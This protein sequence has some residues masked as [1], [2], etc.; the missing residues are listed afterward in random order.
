MLGRR[1]V[2]GALALAVWSA[3]ACAPRPN[4]SVGPTNESRVRTVDV[5]IDA[6]HGGR[7]PGN[8]GADRATERQEKHLVLAVARELADELRRR[9][10]TAELVR[11]DDRFLTLGQRSRIAN[12]EIPA[13]DGTQARG[14]LFVSLH[15]NGSIPEV[16]GT[17]SYWSRSKVRAA[18]PGAWRADSAAATAVHAGLAMALGEIF[19]GCSTDRSVREGG[20]SVLRRTE[21]PAVLVEMGFVSNRCQQAAVSDPARRTRLARALADGVRY[22]LAPEREGAQ[23]L[24]EL[25]ELPARPPQE[26]GS[27]PAAPPRAADRSELDERFEAETFPP[28]GWRFASP[29][30]D[31]V[32]RW[33]PLDP[34]RPLVGGR[35]AALADGQVRD[36]DSWLISPAVALRAGG[37]S[38]TFRWAGNRRTT[39]AVLAECRVRR[40][41]TDRWERVWTLRTATPGAEYAWRSAR[42]DLAD[43]S[44]DTVEVAFRAAGGRGADFLLDDVKIGRSDPA[45][46]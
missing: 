22:A 19:P 38:L 25:F 9:G 13:P 37:A 40:S 33:R 17:E 29:T 14:R 32:S 44:G 46:H 28:V 20:F 1:V 27:G 43:W 45:A 41:R 16:V 18:S 7:D 26:N 3:F 39:A 6:G 42:V 36:A 24:A 35:R 4:P 15:L 23:P 31:S 2:A 21:A 34:A 10:Y 11:D 30:G 5:W 8:L 12:G